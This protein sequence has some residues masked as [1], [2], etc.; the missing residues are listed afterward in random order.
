MTKDDFEEFTAELTLLLPGYGLRD[1]DI[2]A[3]IYNKRSKEAVRRVRSKRS[4]LKKK[5]R[6]DSK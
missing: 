1:R 2:A 6:S 3:A 5:R 4:R